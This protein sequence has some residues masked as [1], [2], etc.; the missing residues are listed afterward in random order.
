MTVFF[1]A[2]LG[3]ALLL[4]PLAASAFTQGEGEPQ[5]ECRISMIS[6]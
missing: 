4:S 5:G 3:S 6:N 1:N 2:L